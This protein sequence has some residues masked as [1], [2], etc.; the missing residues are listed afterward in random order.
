MFKLH[1]PNSQIYILAPAA[2][3][4]PLPNVGA[5]CDSHFSVPAAMVVWLVLRDMLLK[6]A[7]KVNVSRQL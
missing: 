1:V 7:H 2:S 5:C 6:Y 3:G 4:F